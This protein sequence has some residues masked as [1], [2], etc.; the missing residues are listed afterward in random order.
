MPTKKETS[1]IDIVTELARVASNATCQHCGRRFHETPC[2]L[3]DHF[4][5]HAA[6]EDYKRAQGRPLRRR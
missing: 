3:A 1:F 6:I 5:G 2:D 4:E